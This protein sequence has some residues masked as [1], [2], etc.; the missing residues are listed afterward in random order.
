MSTDYDALMVRLLRRALDDRG[1]TLSGHQLE[2]IGRFTSDDSPQARIRTVD[3]KSASSNNFK[4]IIRLTRGNYLVFSEKFDSKDDVILHLRAVGD[5][6]WPNI[7]PELVLG[8]IMTT[9]KWNNWGRSTW[10]VSRVD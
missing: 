1:L 3:P 6:L 7:T 10:T 2:S 5:I 4:L 8:E 9:G